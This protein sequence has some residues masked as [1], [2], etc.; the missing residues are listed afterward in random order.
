MQE[1]RLRSALEKIYR[2]ALRAV[3][4]A[5]AVRRS[6]RRQDEWL[7][8]GKH[9]YN[10][11]EF[12]RVFLVGGGK[13]GAAMAGAVELILGD[14]LQ[15][16]L[17]VVKKGSRAPARALKRT[18]LLEAGHPEPNEAGWRASRQMF[19][20]LGENLSRHDLLLVVLSGGGSALLCAPVPEVS[21]QDKKKTTSVLLR[22]GATIQEMN[23][24]R[25]HLSKIKG[26]RLLRHT[27]GARVITLMLSDVVGDDPAS[28]ASGPTAPDPT[29]FE[30][31]LEIIRRYGLRNQLPAAVLKHLEKGARAAPNQASARETLKTGD[32][33]F[34]KVQN[35]LVASNILALKAAA[36]QADR[37]GFKPLILSSSFYGNTA[38]LARFQVSIAREVLD[39]GNPIRPPCCLISGG[40][41]T[42]RV[43]GDGKGGRNQ[44]FALWCVRETADWGEAPVLF[45]AIGSDGEDGPTDAAGALATPESS[46]RAA[47]MNLSVE[48]HL[49]RND[50]YPF[51]KAL[52][53]LIVTGPTGTNVMD[54]QLVLI[55][56]L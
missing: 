17:V 16:G 46:R 50:S 18:Q 44:E 31:C 9:S 5:A 24:I 13:A 48:D 23:A 52:G 8:A 4:P 14:R 22:S 1:D 39:T 38:D 29:T 55:D 3:D 19:D 10:L 26:G 40:E 51:F 7:Q 2:A 20:F 34:E 21:F 11:K 41:T 15:A 27:Q 25:K 54:I 30:D 28:I 36:R 45:A 49:E 6:L 12:R 33:R 43:N 56:Q 47:D 32:A 42:I 37:L 35:I 53:D